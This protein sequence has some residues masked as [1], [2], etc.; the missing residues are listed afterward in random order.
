MQE[1]FEGI[2]SKANRRFS[3]IDTASRLLLA[4]GRLS[5]A[6]RKK[7]VEAEARLAHCVSWT[8]AV[9]KQVAVD[10]SEAL[11]SKYPATCGYCAKNP[12]ECTDDRPDFAK[13]DT[14][15]SETNLSMQQWQEHLAAM[16]GEINRSKGIDNCLRRL[17]DEA[18]EVIEIA[19][20]LGEINIHFSGGVLEAHKLYIGEIADVFA[21]IMA[22]ADLLN[23]NL[24]EVVVEYYK[25]GCPHCTSNPCICPPEIQI[26][27]EM[28]INVGTAGLPPRPIRRV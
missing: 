21:W 14:N 5:N 20:R 3:E 16:Y 26:S 25:N 24:E 27:E 17:F 10:V 11:H 15:T 2:Y 19:E 7:P 18:T 22:V 1:Y 9:A 12:C 6:L 28:R 8:F 23:I 13:Q 4:I